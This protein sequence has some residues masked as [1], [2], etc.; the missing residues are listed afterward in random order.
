MKERPIIFSSEMVR[1]ILN[2]SKQMTRRVIKP[3]PEY[4][5]CSLSMRWKELSLY[6]REII[7]QCP[8]GQTGQRLWVRETWAYP[9][10]Y[11]T[12]DL[13]PNK[14]EIFLKAA[15][16]ILA[17]GNKWRPSIFMPRW[18]SR[19]TLE[20]REVGVERLQEIT[21][22]DAKAE[23]V[24]T[25]KQRGSWKSWVWAYKDLWNSLNAKRG[26]GWFTNPWVWVIEFKVVSDAN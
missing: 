3:Q 20:I 18:A 17:Q 8:C 1:A 5:Q 19:I 4:D 24:I 16:D 11:N 2:G 10:D 7:E 13:Q 9:L 25:P 6:G 23:G 26:Y 15:S 14:N 21:E 22:E 12:P